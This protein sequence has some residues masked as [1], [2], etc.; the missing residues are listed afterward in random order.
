MFL[1][2]ENNIYKIILFDFFFKKGTFFA[3]GGRPQPSPFAESLERLALKN[4]QVIKLLSKY[5][6]IIDE[7]LNNCDFKRMKKTF[8]TKIDKAIPH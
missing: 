8:T 3:R 7:N 4:H 6:K 2:R 1:K 5:K